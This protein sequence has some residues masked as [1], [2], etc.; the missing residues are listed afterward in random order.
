MENVAS[1][2]LFVDSIFILQLWLLVVCMVLHLILLIKYTGE[3]RVFLV[4]YSLSILSK[5]LFHYWYL[6][7]F[8]VGGILEE[9]LA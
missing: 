4:A 8:D 3:N 6:V 2:E 9:E 7:P 5:M 1:G